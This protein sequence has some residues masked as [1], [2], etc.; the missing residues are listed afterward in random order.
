MKKQLLFLLMIFIGSLGMHAQADLGKGFKKDKKSIKTL[1]QA[2]YFFEEQGYL[3]ALPYYRSL[4]SLYGTNSYLI[5][6]IGICLLYKSDETDKALEYLLIVKSK[7]SKA[8]NIDLYLAHAYHLNGRYD[9]A[10]A[11]LDIY[12]KLKNNPPEKVSE[13]AILRQYCINAKDLISKPVAAKITNIGNPINTAASEY[14]P[15]VS[16]DDSVMLFTYRGERSIGG[17]QSYPGVSDSSGIYFED[18]FFTARTDSGWLVPEPMDS[19]INGNGHDACIGIS[20]D[21]QTLLIYKDGTGGGDI[22]DITMQGFYWSEPRP[23]QGDINSLAWEGSATFSA[24]MHTIYFASERIGG[25]GGRD[26]WMATF[27]SD[28][29]WGNVKNLGPKINTRFNEDAP[30]LHP[31]GVTFLFSSEGHNSMG[32]YD[33][34]RTN[35]TPIDSSYSEPSDPINIG[36]PI[37]TPGDDKYFVL[38]TDGKHGYYSSGKSGGMGQQ[39]IYVVDADFDL[40]NVNVMLFDGAITFNDKPVSANVIIKDGAQKLRT[41]DLQS[42][43][44]SGDYSVTLPLE[45]KYFVTY[46]LEGC[47]SQTL[48]IDSIQSEQMVSKT[49]DIKFYS[50]LFRDSA[51]TSDSLIKAR[52]LKADSIRTIHPTP[53]I[54][55]QDYATS[56]KQFG[57]TKVPGLYYRVQ[58][59]AYTIP[60]NYNSAH[61]SKFG[62]IDKIILDDKITRFTLGKFETLNEAETYRQEIIIA[63]QTDAFVTAEKEGKRYLI[64]DLF[65]LHFFQN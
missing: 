57:N 58:I 33:I 41:I 24:D 13:S 3:Q 28:S 22:Y 40:N 35:L 21:G 10:L 59:A 52:Q 37:N 19:T 18:V 42:K 50:K 16:T 5:Y 4:D 30:F 31:N 45:H 55:Y 27:Q 9:E 63:G 2:E 64:K 36:Y 20:N 48:I 60:K 12:D 61:L 56:L 43:S 25:Y 34:F 1:Q 39:D 51:R 47:E 32:G 49:V 26:I 15:V 8:A 6:K 65:N 46:S 62:K 17:L 23:L 29:T 54:S 44:V 7:N 38:A 14:V 53:E 11:S